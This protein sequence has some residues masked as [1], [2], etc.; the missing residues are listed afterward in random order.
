MCDPKNKGNF[1]GLRIP[2]I[3]RNFAPLNQRRGMSCKF[4]YYFF[5]TKSILFVHWTTRGS[6]VSAP[7]SF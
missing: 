7:Y 6:T 1:E 5:T 2:V 4:E 3:L